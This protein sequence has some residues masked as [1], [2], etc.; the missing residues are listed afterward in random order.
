MAKSL[1][2]IIEIRETNY[3]Q[4][5]RVKKG[6]RYVDD[7]GVY[8][9]VNDVR[10]MKYVWEDYSQWE[11]TITTYNRNELTKKEAQEWGK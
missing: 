3:Q 9:E 10:F 7:N 11:L 2:K 1:T 8:C 4:E 5:P 6:D